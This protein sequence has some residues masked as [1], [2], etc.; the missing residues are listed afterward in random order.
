M[1]DYDDSFCMEDARRAMKRGIAISVDEVIAVARCCPTLGLPVLTASLNAVRIPVAEAA[2]S[3][4]KSIG[5]P[6]YSALITAALQSKGTDQVAAFQALARWGD[7]RGVETIVQAI[8]LD[9]RDAAFKKVG[10]V[11]L[12]SIVVAA[13]IA[14]IVG[15]GG[16]IDP[17]SWL[18]SRGPDKKKLEHTG[19]SN[20]RSWAAITCQPDNLQYVAVCI[21][22]EL[23]GTVA[24]G[25][26]A[27][28]V[29]YGS[30][31]VT[32]AATEM[33]N[34]LLTS[35]EIRKT[36]GRLDFGNNGSRKLMKAAEKGGRHLRLNIFR[37]MRCSG[38]ATVIPA[39]KS[40][41]SNP[42]ES[43]YARQYAQEAITQIGVNAHALE[44]RETLLRSSS[45]CAAVDPTVL[46]RPNSGELAMVPG[47]MLRASSAHN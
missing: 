26:L 35:E 34:K 37:A 43:P 6:A 36:N 21:L 13:I 9:R 22:A 32:R 41:V 29:S 16:F 31:A 23:P 18:F 5:V 4:L 10:T 11:A 19:I 25:A 7:P 20:S 24:A 46:L 33:L 2:L 39:L 38:D 3:A 27:E 15:L 14:I 40:I 17:L 45:A 12:V 30:T 42:K 47:E 8:A 28:F 1:H 44:M